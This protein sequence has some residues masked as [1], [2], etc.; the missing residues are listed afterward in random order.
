MVLVFALNLQQAFLVQQAHLLLVRRLELST[1]LAE[2]AGLVLKQ[3]STELAELTQLPELPALSKSSLSL[4]LL[5]ALR[6]EQVLSIVI[7]EERVR[8]R[9]DIQNGAAHPTVNQVL[10][11]DEVLVTTAA[12]CRR[13]RPSR[14][15]V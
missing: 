2:L 4:L 8:V 15:L 12:P 9:Q 13:S 11:R 10:E 6:T 5:L 1:E 3:L 14:P 7:V